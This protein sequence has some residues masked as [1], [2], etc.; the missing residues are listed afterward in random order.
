[1]AKELANSTINI[2]PRPADVVAAII[3]ALSVSVSMSESGGEPVAVREASVDVALDLAAQ[4]IKAL[5]PPSTSASHVSAIRDLRAGVQAAMAAELESLSPKTRFKIQ[6]IV[7]TQ[8]PPSA[9]GG[10]HRRRR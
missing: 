4:L 2:I 10:A 6:D 8:T 3:H 5:G 1:M 7:A 9:T